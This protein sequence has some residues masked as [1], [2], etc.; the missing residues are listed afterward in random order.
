MFFVL[1]QHREHGRTFENNVRM[2]GYKHLDTAVSAA[3]KHKPALV[4]DEHRHVIA[5]SVSPA[6]PGYVA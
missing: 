6:V 4:R 5:Q 2:G 1:H 3:V